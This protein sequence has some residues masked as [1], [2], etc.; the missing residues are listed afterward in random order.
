MSLDEQ[1]EIVRVSKGGSGPNDEYVRE[2]VAAMR[3]HNIQDRTLEY[4][5]AKLED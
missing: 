3:Q 5:V 2:T 1:A 4:I